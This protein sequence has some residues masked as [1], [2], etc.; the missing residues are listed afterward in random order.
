MS[1]GLELRTGYFCDRPSFLA[2]AGLLQDIFDIDIA[3]LDRFGGPDLT[4]T[5][6]GYFDSD[7]RC[8]ANFSA[9]SMPLVVDGNERRNFR[10]LLRGVSEDR[11]KVLID[12]DNKRFELP[13]EDIDHAKLVPDWDAVMAGKSGAGPAQ[14]KP[15]KPGHRPSKKQKN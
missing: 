12:V 10:G 9:F 7:G 2:L 11:T 14:P 15:V 5:P 8:V 6:F 4:A 13:I 3:L 1:K